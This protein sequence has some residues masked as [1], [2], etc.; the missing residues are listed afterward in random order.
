MFHP[1]DS[2]IFLA[3]LPVAACRP[4]PPP[5]AAFR[6]P[7]EIVDLSPTLSRDLPA[8]SL[9]AKAAEVFG[10]PL[11]TEFRTHVSEEPFYISTSSYTL[12][13]HTGP[14]YDPPNH[15]I[16]GGAAVDDAPLEKFF[17]KARLFDFR[18][19]PAGEAVPRSAFESAGIQPEEI[20]VALFG[21]Q[22]PADAESLPTYAYLSGEA[23]EYLAQIPIKA[24]ASDI[25]S[26]GS[27]RGYLD[28][29]ESGKK[30]SE[31]ILPE[32]YAFLSRGIP[33]IEGLSNLERLVG[34]KEFVLVAFPLKVEDGDGSPVRPAALLY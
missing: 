21:Y 29:I 31:N 4:S 14:H 12:L 22:A 15:V 9:G 7:R 19:T 5:E 11:E 26:L 8:R 1:K 6:M 2:L 33:N 13:N 32:H 24:F 27:I 28:Q 16:Q 30:G 18:S 3:F 20:V 34:E 10:M 25:P 17:G 23:A